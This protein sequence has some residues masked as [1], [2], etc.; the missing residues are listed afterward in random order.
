MSLPIHVGAYSGYKANDRPVRFWLD[1]Q[2]QDDNEPTGLFE[3]A[4]V[5]DRWYDPTAEYFKVRT[6]DGKRYVLRYSLEEDDWTLQSAFDGAA[7]LER[8]GIEV[9]S[10]DAK[11]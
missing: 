3:I 1:P 8:P 10:V 11:A 4:E 9:I 2:I 5:E 7:L 6:T